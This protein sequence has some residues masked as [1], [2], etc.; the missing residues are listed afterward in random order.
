MTIRVVALAQKMLSVLEATREEKIENPSVEAETNQ[1]SEPS[2]VNIFENP[3]QQDIEL[4]EDE[5]YNYN[6]IILI[7]QSNIMVE[8]R[9]SSTSSPCCKASKPK[10]E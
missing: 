10:E 9:V 2:A 8:P 6:T 3:T 1:Y 5:W 7:N 4:L